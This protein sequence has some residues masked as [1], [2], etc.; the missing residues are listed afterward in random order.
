MSDVSMGPVTVETLAM[1]CFLL[2][3]FSIRN[4]YLSLVT[5]PRLCLPGLKCVSTLPGFNMA[6]RELRRPFYCTSWLVSII[7][8]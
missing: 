1:L 3:R 4:G 8:A 7:L 6:S 2:N 5:C